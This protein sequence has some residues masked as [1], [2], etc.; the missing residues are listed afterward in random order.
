MQKQ[1]RPILAATIDGDQDLRRLIYPYIGSP[2]VDGI[3]CY[4]HPELGPVTRSLKPIPNAFIRNK[5][6]APEL[7]GLDGELVVGD[8]TAKDVFNRTTSAVM[9]YAGEPEFHY[10]TFDAYIPGSR[11]PYFTRLQL[12]RVALKDFGEQFPFFKGLEAYL[13]V[14]SYDDAL[15]YEAYAV[16]QG[17]EGLM[18]RKPGGLYKHGRSTLKEGHLL[19]LKRFID[20]EA[21]IIGFEALERN[22]NPQ[23]RNQ[24]GLAERGHSQSG[25]VADNLLGRLLVRHRVFGEFSIGSGFDTAQRERVWLNQAAYLGRTVTFKYQQVGVVDKPRFPIFLRFRDPE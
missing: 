6:S 8:I 9:S 3:R 20:D 19:K 2:K 17:Y 4:L 16:E 13:E 1:F 18:L 24:L 11:I 14:N 23:T 21:I 7:R 15:K 12:A 10:W 5:L 22:Q 25:R